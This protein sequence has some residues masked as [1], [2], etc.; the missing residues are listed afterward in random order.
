MKDVAA[1]AEVAVATVSR[2]INGDPTVRAPI[3]KAVEQ[4]VKDLGYRPNLAAR[5]LRTAKTRAVGV[6]VPELNEPVALLVRGLEAEA[7]DGGYDMLL[8]VSRC[9]EEVQ[10]ERIRA[11]AQ[12]QVDGILCYPVTSDRKRLREIARHLRIPLVVMG[13]YAADRELPMAVANESRGFDAMLEDLWQLGHRHIGL[14]LDQELRW[15]SLPRLAMIRSFLA[16]SK[17]AGRGLTWSVI[18]LSA[19][20]PAGDLGRALEGEAPPTALVL[21]ASTAG[22]LVMAAL[23]DLGLVVPRDVSVV[24]FN[25]TDVA[26]RMRPRLATVAVDLVEYERASAALLLDLIAGIEPGRRPV[27]TAVYDRRDSVGPAPLRKSPAPAPA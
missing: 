15:G 8:A 2:V 6:V 10:A 26:L 17:W 4:A 27:V 9:S 1:R 21:V 13:G 16:T 14:A 11:L 25:R 7:S 24:L 12:R 22:L 23:A 5:S 20:T 3:R 18:E 19:E